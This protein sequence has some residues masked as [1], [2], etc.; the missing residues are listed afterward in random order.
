MLQPRPWAH[1]WSGHGFFCSACRPLVVPRGSTLGRRP[2]CLLFLMLLL[3][4]RGRAACPDSPGSSWQLYCPASAPRPCP[5]PG[6]SAWSSGGGPARLR[7]G[8]GRPVFPAWLSK[9][10]PPLEQPGALPDP[11]GPARTGVLPHSS[12]PLVSAPGITPAP[13]R[14]DRRL[15]RCHQ[16]G[17]R[18]VRV[19]LHSFQT[20][21]ATWENLQLHV[22]FRIW[23]TVPEETP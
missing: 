10:R 7:H 2:R 1:V 9:R 12:V 5:P 3:P 22:N 11:P 15:R 4:R 17:H 19:Q 20:V 8:D 14:P 21:W 13:G 16:R 18:E 23:F 6:P